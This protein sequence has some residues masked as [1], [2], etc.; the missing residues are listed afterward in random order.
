MKQPIKSNRNSSFVT[1]TVFL[2]IL[3]NL[4]NKVTFV[5]AFAWLF[6]IEWG[7][8]IWF[9]YVNQTTDP[10]GPHSE[11]WRLQLSVHKSSVATVLKLDFSISSA[12]SEGK[13]IFYREVMLLST[14]TFGNKVALKCQ[15]SFPKC[16]HNGCWAIAWVTKE[17]QFFQ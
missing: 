1:K 8:Y 6:H 16:Q 14:L 11:S 15:F 10:L 3:E 7:I 13:L 4:C 2:G 9:W 17:G 5:A 12:F